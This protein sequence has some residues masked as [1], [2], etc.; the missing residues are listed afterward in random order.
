MREDIKVVMD[1][2]PRE[3]FKKFVARWYGYNS[4]NYTDYARNIFNGT[5][6]GSVYIERYNNGHCV[7]FG[8]EFITG[9]NYIKYSSTFVN[10]LGEI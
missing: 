6:K 9:Y 8:T 3:T 2:P 1:I 4:C 10:N 7:I 5:S